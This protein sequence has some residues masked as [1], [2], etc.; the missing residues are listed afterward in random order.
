MARTSVRQ[1]AEGRE[2]VSDLIEALAA[3]G[4][5]ATEDPAEDG[6][7]DAVVRLV[8]G[9]HL[10]VQVK[11]LVAPSP[12]E[13]AHLV[14]RQ[15]PAHIPLLVADRITPAGRE[16][17]NDA[18]WA[19]LDR[20]GHLRLR[21]GTLILDADVP[22]GDTSPGRSRPVLE[23]EV[24]LD[25]AC[26]LLAHPTERLSVRHAV[27]ITGRSLAAVHRAVT[28]LADAG[29]TDA[30]RKPVTPDLFWEVVPR[31]RPERAALGLCPSPGDAA[32]SDQLGLGLE[33]VEDTEGW[34]VCDTVAANAY[35]AFAVIRG[36]FPPDFYVPGG[37]IIRLALHLYGRAVTYESRGA[38]VA[39]PPVR[40]ACQR[41]IDTPQLGRDHP[42]AEWPV[43]HPLLAAL[44]LAREPSRGREILESWTPPD[45]FHRVW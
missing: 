3:L 33:D 23:T 6:G 13:I 5:E 20:R 29:L 17:L 9:S 11:A 32:R 39:V 41:R 31:W 35:G 42:W 1:P 12:A 28:G 44:D 7:V 10:L 43:V 14:R 19:W 45:P 21:S 27:Q 4:V 40:W 16:A 37:R 2:A 25:V 15:S 26:A 8:D 24:G 22:G 36:D 18:G 34:A 38:T 30:S